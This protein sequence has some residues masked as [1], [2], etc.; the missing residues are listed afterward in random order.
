MHSIE[1]VGEQILMSNRGNF[2]AI[3]TVVSG[4]M[5]P[6][7]Y[8]SH[9]LLIEKNSIQQKI[10]FWKLKQIIF[11]STELGLYFKFISF[12]PN[13]VCFFLTASYY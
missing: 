10:I 12:L 8:P 4:K 13:L 7:K 2:H 3:V 5:C 11:N 1:T 9:F 6:L